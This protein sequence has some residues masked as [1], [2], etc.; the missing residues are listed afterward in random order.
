MSPCSCFLK[1][2]PTLFSLYALLPPLAMRE[3][4]ATAAL[5]MLSV[6]SNRSLHDSI[7]TYYTTC[8][9]RGRSIVLHQFSHDLQIS[10]TRSEHT[11]HK[12]STSP[13]TC[14]VWPH[15]EA[16]SNTQSSFQMY[17]S[18]R[19]LAAVAQP[20]AILGAS[21]VPSDS[22]AVTALTKDL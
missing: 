8:V 17:M 16:N 18:N 3:G 4:G 20:M 21:P 9:L 12:C 7:I 19:Q 10:E 15:F 5:S 11:L 14:S 2:A 22:W 13:K 6:S 1:R